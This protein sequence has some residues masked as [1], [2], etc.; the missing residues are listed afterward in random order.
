MSDNPRIP[1]D[2]LRRLIRMSWSTT[3]EAAKTSNMSSSV[4]SMQSSTRKC[5]RNDLQE[6]CLSWVIL[7]IGRLVNR[8]KMFLFQERHQLTIDEP[9]Y[10]LWY[11]SYFRNLPVILYVTGAAFVFFIH[12]VTMAWRWVKVILSV[13]KHCTYLPCRADPPE[14][15]PLIYLLGVGQKCTILSCSSWWFFLLLPPNIAQI[16][17]Q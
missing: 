10:Q 6:N 2:V 11:K 17:Q 9:L 12:R 5:V 3:V 15:S 14:Q 16:H 7:S 4:M 13:A 1:N 8:K